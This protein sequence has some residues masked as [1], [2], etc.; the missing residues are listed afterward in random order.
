MLSTYTIAGGGKIIK[1]EGK[2]VRD[3]QSQYGEER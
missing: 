3:P 2:S 1:D